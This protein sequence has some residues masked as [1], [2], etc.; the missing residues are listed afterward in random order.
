MGWL[1]PQ[2]DSG[3]EILFGPAAIVVGDGKDD[4]FKRRGRGEHSVA[5]SSRHFARQ[6]GMVVLGDQ[7]QFPA[8]LP[9]DHQHSIDRSRPNILF[10]VCGGLE[11]RQGPG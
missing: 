2:I 7:D 10:F 6:A 1:A 8:P 3:L 11:N 5:H 4:R 9:P